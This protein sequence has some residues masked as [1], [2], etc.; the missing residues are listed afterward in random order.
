MAT[1][2]AEGIN[3]MLS[4]LL[5]WIYA[6]NYRSLKSTIGLGLLVFASLV[7]VQN[8]VGIYLHLTTGEFYA[9]MLATQAFAIEGLETVALVSL[10]YG[11]WKE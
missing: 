2:Y 1:I 4:L 6:Q 7:L 11:A 8:L 3:T 5:T 10:A 9:K